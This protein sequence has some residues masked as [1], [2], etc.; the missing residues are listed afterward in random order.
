MK[1]EFVHHLLDALIEVGVDPE[2]LPAF[3]SSQKSLG[4]IGICYELSEIIDTKM[5]ANM[6]DDY[7]GIMPKDKLVDILI[8][9]DIKT[10]I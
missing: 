7:L 3:I 2:N 1:G 8:Y 5:I 4:E 6:G 10:P 9:H